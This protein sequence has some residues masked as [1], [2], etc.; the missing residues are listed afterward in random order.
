[1]FVRIHVAPVFASA[2][3]QEQI[4]GRLFMYWFR[5]WGYGLEGAPRDSN[6]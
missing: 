1:M 5:A 6:I 2:R 4:L 3:I